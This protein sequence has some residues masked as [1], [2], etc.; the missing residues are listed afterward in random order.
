MSAPV[1]GSPLM[2]PIDTT[3]N[4]SPLRGITGWGHK[5]L[6]DQSFDERRR[7]V[8][9]ALRD[10][11]GRD[12][13]ISDLYDDRAVYSDF[14]E[15]ESGFYE[16]PYTLDDEGKV[17]LGERKKVEREVTY[18]AVKRVSADIIEGPAMPFGFDV[19]GEAFTSDTDFCFDWFGKSGRPFLFDHGLDPA[20]KGQVFGRQVDYELRDE[21]VWA[22]VQLDRN[23]RYRKAIDGLI[24]QGAIGFSSGAM[25]H[26]ATKNLKGEITRWPWVELSGTPIPAHPAALNVHYVK[27]ADAIRHL[28]AVSIQIPDP[29]K[30]ALA[31]LDEW[32]DS[33]GSDQLPDTASLVEKA[34]RVTAAVTDLRDHA[35][36][37]ADM[38]GKSG[39]VLSAQTRERLMRHPA[40]L[41]ELADDFDGLLTEADA[42]NASKSLDLGALEIA[43]QSV[44]AR[45][46]GVV[47]PEGEPS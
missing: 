12:L 47:I 11:F 35:R 6:A 33:R 26:L 3:T 32:A 28:E 41:R 40:S 31:A 44:L 4:E 30:A 21:G 43:H 15:S 36:A 14:S 38:R 27:S 46:N 23:A 22:Q 13:Y 45:L 5:A 39:R 20:L 25:P 24:E 2:P 34:G 8:E 17:E 18:R 7:V 9:N 19:D 37:Y 1:K 16:V 10:A 42:V 29:L